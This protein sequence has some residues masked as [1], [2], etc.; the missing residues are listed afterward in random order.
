MPS[1]TSPRAPGITDVIVDQVATRALDDSVPL[2]NAPA[3]W[4]EGFTGTGTTVAVIDDGVASGHPNLAGKVVAEACFTSPLGCA[5]NP[6]ATGPGTA[7]PCLFCT[8][9][10]HVA[11]IAAGAGGGF[12][13]VA[14]AASVFAI[15]VFGGGRRERVLL[16]CHAGPRARARPE[17][18]S[19]TSPR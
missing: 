18:T 8:H 3:R 7:E 9:G 4:T 11:G 19:S 2:V 17:L 15:R 14:P 1:T 10:T 6:S 12:D 5:G 16:R 13:G